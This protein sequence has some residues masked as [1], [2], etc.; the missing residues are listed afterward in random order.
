MARD[1]SIKKLLEML[2]NKGMGK[3]TCPMNEN[4]LK[5]STS[6]LP[7]AD[8]VTH[9]K[10]DTYWAHCVSQRENSN[11][12]LKCW[13]MYQSCWTD[14]KKKMITTHTTKKHL[15]KFFLI[16]FSLLVP[17]PFL[18]YDI[19]I[20][21]IAFTISYHYKN[22]QGRRTSNVSTNAGNGTETGEYW[23]YFK[24]YFIKLK[25]EQLKKK[26][27]FCSL[28]FLRNFSLIHLKCL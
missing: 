27:N 2:Q 4:K 18:L 28:W 6:L 25:I 11:S 9:I 21:L 16:D 14:L 26:V 17:S 3:W 15:L 13:R 10:F 20:M 19:N 23:I 22:R 5:S 7:L 8:D 12:M 24:C 1:E